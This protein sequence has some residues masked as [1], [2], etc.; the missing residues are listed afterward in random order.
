MLPVTSLTAVA[1]SLAFVALGIVVIRRRQRGRVAIGDGND[2]N[3]A[4]AIRAQ[5][6]LGEYGLFFLALLGLAELNGTP[7]LWLGAL[8]ATFLAG[9]A[10][11]ARSLLVVEQRGGEGYAPYR[12]RTAGMIATFTVIALSAATLLVVLALS[13][14]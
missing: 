7:T 2:E 9:R 6:N 4:R 8:A 13:R 3:L 11:H 10:A 1:L 12:W 14:F 5:G